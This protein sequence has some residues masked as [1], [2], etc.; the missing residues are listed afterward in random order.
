[1]YSMNSTFMFRP[2]VTIR[3]S[4]VEREQYGGASTQGSNQ[5]NGVFFSLISKYLGL[6]SVTMARFTND[7]LFARTFYISELYSLTHIYVT[8]GRKYPPP[9]L[10]W[11]F[12][13]SNSPR[14]TRTPC[15]RFPSQMQPPSVC[16]KT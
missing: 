1:M 11:H 7:A 15:I 16:Q 6:K 12:P 9:P 2:Y 13:C 4:D 5:G 14:L 3:H 10:Q 8:Y